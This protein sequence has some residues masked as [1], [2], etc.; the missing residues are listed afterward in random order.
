EQEGTY[1]LPEAQIDRFLMKLVVSYPSRE[2][3]QSIVKMIMNETNLPDVPHVVD[4]PTLLAL[5]EATRRVF[6]EEKLIKYITDLVFASRFPS[7]YGLK[8]DNM[9]QY[10][11]SPRASIALAQVARARALING[12][13]AVMPEDIKAAVN[14]VMRHRIIPTYQAEAEGI[15]SEEILRRIL[16]SVKVP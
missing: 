5:Q 12:E 3:E 2:E 14:D 16:E 6:I 7:E 1:P 4:G 10:G 13:K 15:R 9:I 8:I 11:A